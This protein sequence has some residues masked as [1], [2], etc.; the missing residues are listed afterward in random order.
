M[1]YLR[2]LLQK[3]QQSGGA[4]GHFNISDLVLVKAVFAAA[5]ELNVP[6]LVGLSE[7]E[8]EFVGTRQIPPFVRSLREEFDFP[9]FLNAD[10][11]HPL[12]KGIEP[13]KPGFDSIAFDLSAL[14]TEENGRQTNQPEV[15]MQAIN[16]P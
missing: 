2:G 10:H 16:P 13:P 15:H 8:R 6:V 12:A 9:I 14:P 7:G 5:R 4:I 3:A 1:R 11:P